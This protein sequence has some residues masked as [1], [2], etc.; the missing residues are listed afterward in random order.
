MN[1]G[2]IQIHK[3]EGGGGGKSTRR[4]GLLEVHQK[5]HITTRLIF[6]PLFLTQTLR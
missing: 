3:S 1:L 6:Q 5:I 4:Q 2:N